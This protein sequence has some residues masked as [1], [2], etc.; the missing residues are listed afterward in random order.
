MIA[1]CSCYCMFMLI[2]CRLVSWVCKMQNVR[3]V[4]GRSPTDAHAVGEFN[5]VK[6]NVKSQACDVLW[7]HMHL[8]NS[9]YM[10]FTLFTV[11]E[12]VTYTTEKLQLK[13]RWVWTSSFLSSFSTSWTP[14]PDAALARSRPWT[15]RRRRRR[16]AP[17]AFCSASSPGN[18]APRAGNGVASACKKW[19]KLWNT[20]R[21]IFSLIFDVV[22]SCYF[23]KNV[24]L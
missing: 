20:K 1:G 12:V 16:A 14:S 2:C 8:H 6:S 23:R 7:C 5:H 13:P 18:A 9:T 21:W 22:I 15:P 3:F 19:W 17:G 11:Y 24:S 10:L 4:S